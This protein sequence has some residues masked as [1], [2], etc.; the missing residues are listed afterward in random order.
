MLAARGTTDFVVAPFYTQETISGKKGMIRRQCT[1][2]YKIVPR[3]QKI[4]ELCGVGYG[5]HFPKNKYV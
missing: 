5:K 2:S 1:S 4:R 3:Q